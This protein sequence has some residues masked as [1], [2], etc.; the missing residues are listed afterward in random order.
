MEVTAKDLDM[1]SHRKAKEVL[2]SRGWRAANASTG[3]SE[4]AFS[5]SSDKKDGSR[6]DVGLFVFDSALEKKMTRPRAIE[7]AAFVEHGKKL[8]SVRV[9]KAG[10][11]D[12]A[13]GK[14]LLD[15]LATRARNPEEPFAVVEPKGKSWLEP[16]IET[17]DAH[18]VISPE[19]VERTVAA[20]KALGYDDASKGSEQKRDTKNPKDTG[21]PGVSVHGRQ[22][23]E[24][25]HV[26][27]RCLPEDTS[28]HF[29][30]KPHDADLGE[31]IY[32]KER[33]KAVV[34]VKPASARWSDK[35]KAKALLEKLFAHQPKDG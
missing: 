3:P 23:D 1:L 10:K 29:F 12:E 24:S 18:L 11:A 7:D 13:A 33:C 16:S 35:K 31:A 34:S 20:L 30:P 17:V 26:S 22:G 25:V 8:L 32:T 5:I 2:V 9:K 4:G 14:A 21:H 19:L 6:V 15:A 27:F 28:S